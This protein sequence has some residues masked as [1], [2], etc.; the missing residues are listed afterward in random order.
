MN[1]ELFNKC[2]RYDFQ[3]LFNEKGYAFF[4]N[5]DYNLNIIGVRANIG[6]TVTNKFDDVLIV[7]YSNDK[8][9]HRDIF[10]IT[11]DPGIYYMQN[12][13]NSKGTAILVPAQYRGC[14]KIGTHKGYTALVQAKS[15]KVYRD[16]NKDKQ[17]D[18]LPSSAESG[19][20]SI[21]IHR[22]STSGESTQVDKWSAGCQVFASAYDFNNFMTTCKLAKNKW[23]N[24]FTYTLIEET[25]LS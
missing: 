17:Y 7:D 16:N 19:L 10:A 5:G 9:H 23:G 21:N 8:G 12:P 22:A 4:T 18:M 24:S 6:K 2:L 13:M 14:Y 11:T 3:K 25:D 1:T 20:F 15:V